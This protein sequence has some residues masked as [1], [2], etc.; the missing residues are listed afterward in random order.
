MIRVV[1]V[2][3]QALLRSGFR[4]I[5]EVEEDLTVVGEAS[6]GAEALELIKRVNVDV[7]LMDI[8]MPVMDG[9]EATKL[10]V[11]DP[12]G[13][14]VIILTTFNLDEYVF[15][16]LAA[17]ASGFLLKDTPPESLAEAIR[18]VHGG[19]ALLSPAVT[20]T[21][22][23]QHVTRPATKPHPGIAELTER[24]HEVLLA[25]AAGHSNAEIGTLL[26]VS[27]TTVKTHVG[28]VLSKLGVRDRTQAVVVAY[29]AGLIQ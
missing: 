4:M 26:F 11:D 3:D 20:K 1:I 15:A 27:E 13:P 25:M 28:R 19:D 16:A 6:N 17:G 12:D 18:V 10:I 8:R 29:Q 21:V 7:V 14:R 2:D 23:S 5:L 22:I 24:E 9:V